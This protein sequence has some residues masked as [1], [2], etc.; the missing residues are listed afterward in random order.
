MHASSCANAAA[1]RIK[2]NPAH[3]LAY[4]V[5]LKSRLIDQRS[6]GMC[7]SAVEVLTDA[8][9]YFSP[10]SLLTNTTTHKVSGFNHTWRWGWIFLFLQHILTSEYELFLPFLYREGCF[11]FLSPGCDTLCV[12]ICF[13]SVFFIPSVP[14]QMNEDKITLRA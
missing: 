2:L 13:K 5:E 6:S 9:I 10:P 14:S 3:A 12:I 7:T 11:Q 8:R 1:R 4:L